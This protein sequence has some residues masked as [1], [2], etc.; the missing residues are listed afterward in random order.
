M[1]QKITS[2]GTMMTGIILFFCAFIIT[3]LGLGMLFSYPDQIWWLGLLMLAAA[4]VIVRS[5]I[6][7]VRMANRLSKAADND[8]AV[9]QKQLHK[10]VAPAQR[11]TSTAP[12]TATVP[13]SQEGAQ[14]KE[15]T[16]ETDTSPIIL[17]HWK[18][19]A[20]E[21][22]KFIAWETTERK[23]STTIVSLLIL[24]FGGLTV[25]WMKKAGFVLAFAL[26][27]FIAVIYWVG[28][29]FISK[30]SIGEAG[31]R[32]NEVAITQDAIVIN[33]KYNAFISEMYRLKDIKIRDEEPL[34]V[35]EIEYSWST[36]RG[37]SFDEIRVPIPAGKLEE[38]KWLIKVLKGY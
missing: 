12:Q 11:I 23:T 22:Q 32:Q 24:V 7:N 35:L 38:A 4:V 1:D 27:G 28:R 31:N 15:E 17:A 34:Q 37:E 9:I 16:V 8:L 10:K 33:G 30:F 20:A 29:Y 25:I 36:R 2:V 21:W 18:Y 13:Q 14:A 5:G 19:T 26:S 6:S 3:P